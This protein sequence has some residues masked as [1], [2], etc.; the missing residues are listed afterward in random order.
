M[1]AKESPGKRLVKALTSALPDSMEWTQ[2]E[3][4]TLDAVEHAGNRLDAL[5][6]RFDVAARN[7][8]VT[9]NR[10]AVLSAEIRLLEDAINRWV[11]TLNPDGSQTKSVSAPHQ[12]AALSRWHGASA[13]A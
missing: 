5:R 8:E 10:L 6:K 12:R 11:R 13:S 3:G 9:E 7:P 4:I 2:V 1:T